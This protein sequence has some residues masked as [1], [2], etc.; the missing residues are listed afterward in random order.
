M[1]QC[2]TYIRTNS[3]VFIIT[4]LFSIVS[5]GPALAVEAVVQGNDDLSVTSTANTPLRG[6]GGDVTAAAVSNGATDASTATNASAARP[7]PAEAGW[8]H[9]FHVSGYAGQT[10]GM[11]QNPSALRDFTPSR[12]NLAVSRTALQLDENFRLNET[13]T[14]FMREWFVYEPPYSFNSANNPAYAAGSLA[15]GNASSF[16][17]FHERF[18]QPV[19]GT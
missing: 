6:T 9:N 14:F 16:W 1:S 19:H 7:D 5:A 12:N 13:N 3:C 11:W 2:I 4:I 15:A 10:F 8:F 18:L 17:P